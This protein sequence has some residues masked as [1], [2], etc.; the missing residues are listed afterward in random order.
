MWNPTLQQKRFPQDLKKYSKKTN[1]I[2]GRGQ[3]VIRQSVTAWQDNRTV[4]VI[5]T[6]S[7]PTQ[8]TSVTRTQKD[9]TKMN[10]T[11]PHAAW[12]YN[13][14]MGGLDYNDQLRAYYSFRI[15]SRKFYK[16]LFWFLVELAITNAYILCKHFTDLKISSMKDFRSQLASELIGTFSG[17]KRRG[18]PSLITTPKKNQVELNCR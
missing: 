9:G 7:D 15:K 13:K 14:Y 16:Y 12:A 4:M 6:V 11:C 17:R 3:S 18:R 1:K 8:T 5:S 10:V 2:G